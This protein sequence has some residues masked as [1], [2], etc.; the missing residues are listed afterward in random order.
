MERSVLSGV[1]A[2]RIAIPREIEAMEEA[3]V[4]CH[5]LERREPGGGKW[6]F[7]GDGPW[8]LIRKEAGDWWSG[9]WSASVET[10]EQGREQ[11]LMVRDV[12]APRTPLSSAEVEELAELRRWLLLVP[13][14][15]APLACDHDRRLVWLATMRLEAGEGRVPWKA[16]GLWLG[17]PRSPDALVRRYRMALAGVVCRLNEWPSRRAQKLAA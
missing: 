15:G 10:D 11:S 2:D 5:A 13:D 12:P 8:N 6:P 7:A 16:I 9:E 4:R 17:S 1:G 3:F 14:A